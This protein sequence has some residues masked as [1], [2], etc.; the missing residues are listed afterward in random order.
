MMHLSIH[1]AYEARICG[2]V[3]YR[4]MYP[5]ERFMKTFKAYVRNKTRPEGCIAE[6]YI[7]EETVIFCNQYKGKQKTSLLEKL[8]KRFNRVIPG[9]RKLEDIVDD[10]PNDDDVGP[11]GSG[12]SVILAGIEYEQARRWVLKSHPSYDEWE[13]YV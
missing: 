3:Y 5:F 7:Q 2:P 13:W 12:Q 4:W 11:V 1:L 8:E 10:D 9:L 6:Q